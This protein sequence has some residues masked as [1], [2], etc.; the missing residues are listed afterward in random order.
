MQIVGRKFF[1]LPESM[2]QNVAVHPK[3]QESKVCV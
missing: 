3:L 2:Q 1:E